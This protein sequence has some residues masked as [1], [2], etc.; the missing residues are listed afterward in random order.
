[1]LVLTPTEN[2]ATPADVHYGLTA[3]KA[4]ERS[5]ILATAPAANPKRFSSITDPNILA[6]PTTTWINKPTT[7]TALAA[8]GNAG[9]ELAA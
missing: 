9:T 1:M 8:N 7:N 4:I 3:S 2:R 6:L 5:A